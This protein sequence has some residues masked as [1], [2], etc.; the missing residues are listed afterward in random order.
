MLC[1]VLV[2]RAA[3]AAGLDVRTRCC[4][5][6]LDRRSRTTTP[7]ARHARR[8]LHRRRL[9]FA[10]G[11][12]GSSSAA[13]PW[14][15][16]RRSGACHRTPRTSSSRRGSAPEKSA[17]CHRSWSSRALLPAGH[18][19]HIPPLT[20]VDRNT[21][22]RD[23]SQRELQYS[24]FFSLAPASPP[25]SSGESERRRHG[26]FQTERWSKRSQDPQ[27]WSSVSASWAAA[28]SQA[29]T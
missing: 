5:P 17:R 2:R 27:R 1:Y 4:H 15:R 3:G 16:P 14:R 26:N 28:T 25:A 29:T 20:V 23:Q 7:R 10:A 18:R 22:L 21:I 8:Y 24:R 9:H 12:S 13:A 11:R 19:V 6:P